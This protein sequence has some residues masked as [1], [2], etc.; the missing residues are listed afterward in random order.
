[1]FVPPHFLAQDLGLSRINRGGTTQTGHTPY[2]WESQ[3]P[4]REGPYKLRLVGS[5]A[6]YP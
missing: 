3:A 4:I 5:F 2:L 6:P 1:M